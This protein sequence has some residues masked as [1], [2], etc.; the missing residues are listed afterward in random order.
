MP[1]NLESLTWAVLQE[2]I[3]T[4]TYG[5][6]SAPEKFTYP[7]FLNTIQ[8]TFAALSGL[9]YLYA[10]TSHP[11]KPGRPAPIFPTRKILA[12]LL[13]VS[14]T[15][16]LS[17]PFGYASLGYI[18]Y[19]TFI[20]AKSCK[21]LPL[22]FLH[23]TIFR[24][25]YPVYKYLVVA[26]VT[27]GVAIFTIHHPSTASK[28]AKHNSKNSA[29][30]LSSNK[31]TWGLFLL[32][33]NLLFD[34]LFNS[35]Q[36]YIFTAF[37]PYSGPQM[38][39]AQNIL[40][41]LLTTSYL[42]LSP[43]LA[44]TPLGTALSLPQRDELREALAFVSRHP[45][46]GYDVLAFSICGAFGQV[47]IFHT[48]ATF[49]SLLLVTVNVTRKMLTMVLSVLW[50]GHRISGMQWVGVGLVFG[51]IGGEAVM[52]RREK[53]AKDAKARNRRLSEA[54]KERKKVQ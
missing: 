27:L 48:L 11:H 13:L 47:F 45:S 18:D 9:T 35:T 22:M 43:I 51:G 19:I 33:I 32:G 42:L 34:G 12:P 28:A 16:S 30:S 2:R 46:V 49:S 31:T 15:S 3:T 10:A 29:T 40:A 26:L 25:S 14:I 41:T 54:G 6:K 7:V 38:M 20:L 53:L 21:L 17:S 23:L 37:K 5:S 24:K 50:F 39:C 8:S 44:P 52:N 36:D 1:T 4:T